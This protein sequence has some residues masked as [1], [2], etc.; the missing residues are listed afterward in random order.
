MELADK[1]RVEPTILCMHTNFFSDR[2]SPEVAARIDVR[3]IS[4]PQS[5]IDWYRV[6]RSFRPD[7]VVFVHGYFEA[8]GWPAY[9]GARLAG[10]PRVQSIQHLVPEEIPSVEGSSLGSAVRRLCGYRAR[11]LLGTKMQGMLTDKAICVSNAVRNR[12]TSELGY[13]TGKTTTIWNAVDSSQFAPSAKTAAAVRARFGI[14]PDETVFVCVAR[15]SSQKGIDVLIAAMGRLLRERTPF[16]C[17]IVGDGPNRQTFAEKI[18]ELGL[19]KHVL[20]VGFAEDV[21]PYLQAAD[22]FVLTSYREGLPYAVL[23]A[24]AC[25]LPCVVTNVGGTAEA[26]TDKSEGFV[27]APGSVDEATE[28]LAYLLTH[29]EEREEMGRRARAR[30]RAEFDSTAR[31]EEIWRTILG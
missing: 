15:L 12:L 24:L 26:V 25:G 28:A 8:F 9:M 30:V 1:D 23:E 20:L 7:V 16:R 11:R 31:M 21:R 14:A 22:V 17:L 2:L 18:E 19:S 27:V 10:V 13:R 6:F 29:R 5:V 3:N 4:T